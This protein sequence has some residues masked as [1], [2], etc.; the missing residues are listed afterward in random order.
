M[1]YPELAA[2]GGG[3]QWRP[4]FLADWEIRKELRD[5]T[6]S[7]DRRA[8]LRAEAGERKR[9][10]AEAAERE[11]RQAALVAGGTA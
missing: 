2:G 3:R 8:A 9:D 11:A 4:G 1:T 10:R 6:I 7:Q 5:P